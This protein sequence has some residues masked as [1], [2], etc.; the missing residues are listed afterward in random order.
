MPFLKKIEKNGKKLLIRLI[1]RLFPGPPEHPDNPIRSVILVRIDERLGNVV[2]LNSVIES[3]IRDR[4]RITLVLCRRFGEIYAWDRRIKEIIYFEKKK[5]FNPWNLF[6]LYGQL[7]KNRYDLLFDA[8]NPNDLSLLTLFVILVIRARIKYGYD[9]KES[10][11][12]LNRAI[13]V[14]DRPISIPDYY[15]RLFH[16]IRIPF[17]YQPF[18]KKIPSAV[19]NKYRSLRSGRKRMIIAHPGG[20]GRKQWDVNKMLE[21]LQKLDKKKYSVLMILGPDEKHLDRII[22]GKG[23]DV[24]RLKEIRDLVSL[25]SIGDIYIGN[26]SG[27]M[28]LAAAMGLSVVAVFKPKASIVF[29]PVSRDQK[30][31]ITE[32]PFHVSSDLMYRKFKQLQRSA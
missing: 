28:H 19:R 11:T 14:P 4:I 16:H 25:L 29:R 20:R 10:R 31:V 12:I 26:D 24:Y 17:Y 32:S 2:L 21:L 3:F 5:L 6:R 7:R 18:L 8:S 22:R 13:P 15:Q 27:P 9:R 1:T 30:L 23:Y